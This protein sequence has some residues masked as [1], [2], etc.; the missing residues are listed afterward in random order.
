MTTNTTTTTTHLVA[1]PRSV[2]ADDRIAM[3]MAAHRDGKGTFYSADHQTVYITAT[4]LTLLMKF[5]SKAPNMK[6][7]LPS[8]KWFVADGIDFPNA[9]PV[10]S[11][12]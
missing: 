10:A 12:F 8:L 4:D 3:L 11:P 6:D 7:I 5:V 9:Q 1:I 2:S